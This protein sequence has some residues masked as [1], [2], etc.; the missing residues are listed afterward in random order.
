MTDAKI[1]LPT[2]RYRQHRQYPVPR[3]LPSFQDVLQQRR[4][5]IDEGWRPQ[6]TGISVLDGGK[7]S[8]RDIAPRRQDDSH[9]ER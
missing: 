1:C 5:D 4:V 8:A 6:Q 7:T 9:H 2:E 3:S